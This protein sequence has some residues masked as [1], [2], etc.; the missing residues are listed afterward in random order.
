M[1]KQTRLRA[2]FNTPKVSQVY[3]RRHSAI[4][5]R[6]V[7]PNRPSQE[8]AFTHAQ[9]LDSLALAHSLPEAKSPVAVIRKHLRPVLILL[10][11]KAVNGLGS[12]WDDKCRA[13]VNSDPEA[14]NRPLSP[15]DVLTDYNPVLPQHTG[16][17]PSNAFSA[18]AWQHS[19]RAAFSTAHSPL[20]STT[21]VLPTQRRLAQIT[22][23]IHVASLLHDDVIDKADTRRSR[24]SAPA[25]FGNKLSILGGDFL[26]ARASAALARL[27]DLEVVELVSSMINNLVEGEVV[28]LEEVFGGSSSGLTAIGPDAAR[29]NLYLKK[30]YLKTASLMAKSA[31]ASVVLGGALSR[32]SEATSRL[33][34]ERL[35]DIAYLYGRNIGIAFQLVDDMLDFSTSAELGKPSGGADMQ[36]GLTTA[37]AL[38]AWEEEP[39]MGELISR[40]FSGSGD[41]EMARAIVTSTSALQRTRDLAASYANAARDA[42]RQLPE[43]EARLGLETLCNRQH[44]LASIS[45]RFDV[46]IIGRRKDTH[47]S[48]PTHVLVLDQVLADVSAKPLFNLS[49]HIGTV[50]A[51]STAAF[52]QSVYA[53]GYVPWLRID[54]IKIVPASSFIDP[55]FDDESPPPAR[56]VRRTPNDSG[57]VSNPTSGDITCSIGNYLPSSPITVS[58]P[59]GG[60]VEF[61]WNSWPLGHY[62]P[63]INYMAKCPGSCS[64]WKAADKLA[65]NNATWAVTIPKNLAAGEYLLRHE[66]IALHGGSS[67]GGAQFYPVC[68]QITV[69]GGG[70]AN[71]SGLAFPGAYNATDP[72]ILFK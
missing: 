19:P 44:S 41:V 7:W 67:I 63:V 72:G 11:A 51:I 17:S 3:S 39:K 38:F 6:E 40:R 56:V 4:A 55:L 30:S 27:G 5:A 46:H 25:K 31:R 12:G 23:M 33:S 37:P 65:K 32:D 20:P 52:A 26:L 61:L 8:A 58:V 16:F 57:F 53:H 43:S 47:T 54:G 36:L 62:G 13:L 60:K 42:I 29:W 35:K 2:L 71:P 24:P 64:T 59:A 14:L 48:D 18:Y 15:P 28:Q 68:A 66:I 10:F 1:I 49:M 21:P 9:R 50:V 70:S 22:E 34:D 45:R 69:T